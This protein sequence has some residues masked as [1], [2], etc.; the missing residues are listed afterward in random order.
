MS[1]DSRS[2]H[3]STREDFKHYIRNARVDGFEWMRVVF[4]VDARTETSARIKARASMRVLMRFNT[5]W[6]SVMDSNKVEGSSLPFGNNNYSVE[7]L[8]RI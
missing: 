1:G 6:V 7:L 5:S 3:P 8:T 4:W 2:H